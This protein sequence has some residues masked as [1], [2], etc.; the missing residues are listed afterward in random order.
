MS[1]FRGEPD[2]DVVGKLGDLHGKGRVLTVVLLVFAA[3][4]L[5]G[6]A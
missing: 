4:I 2:S 6:S 3:G 1:D 5:I